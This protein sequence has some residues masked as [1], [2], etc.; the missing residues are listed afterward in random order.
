MLLDVALKN[1]ADAFADGSQHLGTLEYRALQPIVEPI[2][3]GPILREYYGRL[4]MSAIPQM[5]GELMLMLFTLDDLATGQH[6][7]R[8]I[9]KNNGPVMESPAWNKHWIVIADRSGDAIVVDDSTAGGVVLGH[10]GPRNF[11][12]AGDLASFFQVMAEAMMIEA[13]TFN[14]EVLDEDFNHIPEFLDAVSAI[15]LRVLGP[16][17]EAGFMDFF[18]G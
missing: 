4:H 11:K 17:G 18:F 13:N 7:W 9:R 12:I 8:W 5:G 15:A 10:I 16:D 1:F 14:Y 6:G 2:P 3:L